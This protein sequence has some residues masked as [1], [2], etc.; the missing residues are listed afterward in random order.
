MNVRLSRCGQTGEPF[1]IGSVCY[2]GM[3]RHSFCDVVFGP[4]QVARS[5]TVR[6]FNHYLCDS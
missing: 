2:L 5:E 3:S 6:L 1:V 4:N